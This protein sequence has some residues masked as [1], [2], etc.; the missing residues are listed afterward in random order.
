MRCILVV[1]GLEHR[2]KLTVKIMCLFEGKQAVLK[3][4]KTSN[5]C[6]I[7][8]HIINNLNTILKWGK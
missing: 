8:T 7:I 5:H 2:V 4:S 1:S 3:S 6:D